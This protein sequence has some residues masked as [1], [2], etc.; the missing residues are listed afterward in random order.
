MKLLL[1]LLL[2]VLTACSYA[3]KDSDGNLS[4]Y[5]EIGK[6]KGNTI[7]I[8]DGGSAMSIIVAVK[9]DNQSISSINYMNGKVHE[10]VIIIDNDTVSKEEALKLLNK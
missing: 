3:P 4:S 5:Q 6:F 7:Y 9:D 10:S 8:V 1:L 2:L